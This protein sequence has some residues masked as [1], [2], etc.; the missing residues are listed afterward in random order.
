MIRLAGVHIKGVC[1]GTVLIPNVLN[2][3]RVPADKENEPMRLLRV[4]GAPYSES[5]DDETRGRP[6]WTVAPE[7]VT[8]VNY[9]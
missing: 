5:L 7:S 4:S 9:V 2:L 6:G 3:R 8:L 1:V